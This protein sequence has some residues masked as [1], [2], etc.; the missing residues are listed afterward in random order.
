MSD[1]VRDEIKAMAQIHERLCAY[2]DLVAVTSR[3]STTSAP[4]ASP[5]PPRVGGAAGSGGTPSAAD[6]SCPAGSEGAGTEA[7]AGAARSTTEA[8]LGRT[9]SLYVAP[10][11]QAPAERGNQDPRVAASEAAAEGGEDRV[12][13]IV[14]DLEVRR[15]CSPRLL[16]AQ[17]L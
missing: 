3:P 1:G 13:E 16:L 11:P 2:L 7:A 6:Q 9:L 8:P 12:D 15:A 10:A 5:E 17:E 4:G 14:N